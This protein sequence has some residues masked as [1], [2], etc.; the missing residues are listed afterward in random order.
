M[1]GKN[2][3]TSDGEAKK[4][5]DFKAWWGGLDA[6]KRQMYSMLGAGGVVV[7]FAIAIVSTGDNKGASRDVRQTRLENAL[8]PE[9][10]GRELGLAGVSRGQ[11]ELSQQSRELENKVERLSQQLDRLQT[12]NGAQ[13]QAQ[14]M[15]AELESLRNELAA[16]KVEGA[17]ARP[18]PEAPQVPGIGAA[19]AAAQV[20]PPPPPAAEIRS[21]G[22]TPT[23]ASGSAAAPQRSNAEVLAERE[24]ERAKSETEN[25][26]PSGTMITGVLLT[27]IDA[28]T[29]R[30]A[31][32]DPLPVLLRVKREAVLPNRY[33]A[34]YKECFMLLEAVGDLPSERAMMR[35]NGMSCVR[36]DRTV[37]DVPLQGFAV[38]EDGKAGLRGLVVSKQGQAISKAMLAGFADGVSRAFGGNNNQM[39]QLGGGELPSGSDIGTSGVMGGASS[40]LDRIAQ[41][42]LDLAEQ[43]HPV[44]EI[45]SGRQV[46]VILTQG[47]TM[48]GRSG[49][50]GGRGGQR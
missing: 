45:D 13:S 34:D 30:A 40:A 10:G 23:A 3:L 47:R 24:E 50:E 27:G 15:E 4:K 49:S 11:Q 18:N 46:T 35:T 28:P 20:A 8:M 1:S 31:L 6:K 37:I 22:G 17:R 21:V 9:D 7:L 16:L 39:S 25:Y 41:H 43:L 2:T 42:F 32:R 33:R 5:F 38:G 14:R 19:P 36:Q 48:A 29:G 12:S 26:L 44:I